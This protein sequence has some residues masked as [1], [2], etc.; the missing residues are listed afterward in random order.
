MFIDVFGI[1]RYTFAITWLSEVIGGRCNCV[2]F[3]YLVSIVLPG[4]FNYVG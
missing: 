4:C 3:H 1:L 2:T